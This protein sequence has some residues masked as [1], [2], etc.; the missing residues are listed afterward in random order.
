ML[1]VASFVALLLTIVPCLLF[2]S[3]TLSLDTA[4]WTALAGTIIWFAVT[5]LWMGRSLVPDADQVRI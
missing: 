1:R 3:E 4:K 5:P 2:M